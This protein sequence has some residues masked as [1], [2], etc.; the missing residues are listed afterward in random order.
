MPWKEL[1][2]LGDFQKHN[3][4]EEVTPFYKPQ[5]RNTSNNNASSQKSSKLIPSCVHQTITFTFTI[6][7]YGIA[8]PYCTLWHSDRLSSRR[9]V[10]LCYV[11]ATPCLSLHTLQRG[12]CML[13]RGAFNSEPGTLLVLLSAHVVEKIIL[14][15][16]LCGA[17]L[18]PPWPGRL[19]S[20][21][22]WLAN[23]TAQQGRF[24]VFAFAGVAL[25][26]QFGEN[27]IIEPLIFPK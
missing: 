17:L 1:C 2:F 6:P 7:Y 25:A 8:V 24:R 18:F 16:Y 4:K 5:S 11:L 26:L 21:Q 12:S 19:F 23:V 15:S 20:M 27:Q 13:K 22:M 9:A 3:A 14:M 10:L